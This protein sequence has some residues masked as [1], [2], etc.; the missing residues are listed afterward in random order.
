MENAT[1]TTSYWDQ[2]AKYSDEL[3]RLTETHMKPSGESDTVEGELIRIANRLIYEHC[4]NGNC[5]LVDVE[6]G[7]DEY[8]DGYD[9]EGNEEYDY[10]EYIESAD[11]NPFYEQMLSLI[12]ETIPSLKPKVNKLRAMV[13]RYANCELQYK[14]NEDEMKIYNELVDG[15]VEYVLPRE[16]LGVLVPFNGY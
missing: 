16:A 10:E 6:Y 8:V 12:D 13:L 15:I 2:N 7:E 3:T 9:D 11:I 4:N 14:F 1:K 5:N